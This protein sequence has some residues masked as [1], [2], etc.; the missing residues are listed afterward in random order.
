MHQYRYILM[1]RK[2]Y[3]HGRYIYTRQDDVTCYMPP[4]GGADLSAPFGRPKEKESAARPAAP[5]LAGTLIGDHVPGSRQMI[6]RRNAKT[7]MPSN[8]QLSAMPRMWGAPELPI[9]PEMSIYC[10]E[11]TLHSHRVAE[12]TPNRGKITAKRIGGRETDPKTGRFTPKIT[13]TRITTRLLPREIH[14]GG[15]TFQ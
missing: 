4:K 9:K 12:G 11:I 3:P 7:S 5:A 15:G 6:D 13:R 10:T 8:V 1:V 2:T 14:I